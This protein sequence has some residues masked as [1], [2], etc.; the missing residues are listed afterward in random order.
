MLQKSLKIESRQQQSVCLYVCANVYTFI[1]VYMYICLLYIS[2]YVINS[3]ALAWP[4]QPWAGATPKNRTL[5]G[6]S[7][8][9]E[10]R[11]ASSEQSSSCM[12]HMYVWCCTNVYVYRGIGVWVYFVLFCC[13]SCHFVHKSQAERAA[14]AHPFEFECVVVRVSS[15][16]CWC[17]WVLFLLLSI[18]T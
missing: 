7:R 4:G 1:N 18:L 8:R 11:A 2:Y 3:T 15:C 6:L 5:L 14:A 10:M 13:C 16:C 9:C 12:S 17:C